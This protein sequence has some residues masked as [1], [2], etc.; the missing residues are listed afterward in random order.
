MFQGKKIKIKIKIKIKNKNKKLFKF[1]F[2]QDWWDLREAVAIDPKTHY[3]AI[4][5][6]WLFLIGTIQ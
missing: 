6:W 1:F 3:R 4:K 5:S 2:F